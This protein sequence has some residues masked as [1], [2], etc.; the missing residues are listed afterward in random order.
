MQGACRTFGCPF[1]P[2]VKGSKIVFRVHLGLHNNSDLHVV[3][4]AP[5]KI[6]LSVYLVENW[7]SG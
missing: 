5:L 3:R 7:G 1:C 6:R 2:V 4:Q